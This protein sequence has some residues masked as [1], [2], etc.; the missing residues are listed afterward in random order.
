MYAVHRADRNAG[1]ASCAGRFIDLRNALHNFNRT[2]RA[3]PHAS[4]A[5]DAGCFALKDSHI[6][7]EAEQVGLVYDPSIREEYQREQAAKIARAYMTAA[8]SGNLKAI[9]AYDFVDDGFCASEPENNFGIVRRDMTP[10]PAYRALAKV[11]RTF[12]EGTPA[13]E[14][15]RLDECTAFVFRMGGK[16]AVW[17]NKHVRLV[18]RTAAPTTATNLMD[19]ELSRGL[20]ESEVAT[21]PLAPL[22]FD[23][24]I[25]KVESLKTR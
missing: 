2:A 5:G 13:F 24:D 16:S 22:F 8:A 1:S 11:C 12:T 14:T 10:K 23:A 6:P 15:V 7:E 9:F 18:V 20:A 4:A 21:G 25:V 19:E 3:F 17:A